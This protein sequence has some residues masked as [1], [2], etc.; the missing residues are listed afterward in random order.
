MYELMTADTEGR[1]GW[2]NDLLWFFKLYVYKSFLWLKRKKIKQLKKPATYFGL[3]Y[4]KM[5]YIS[6]EPY[7]SKRTKLIMH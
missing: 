7:V 5:S 6:V 2:T 3:F 4:K 1:S